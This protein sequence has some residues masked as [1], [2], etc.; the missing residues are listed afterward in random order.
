MQDIG[1][2]G[3]FLL[4]MVVMTE[5]LK[6]LAEALRWLTR[7]SRHVSRIY[8]YLHKAQQQWAAAGP[9]SSTRLIEFQLPNL[10]G[11]QMIQLSM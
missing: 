5:G 7:L 4:G 9:G 10:C 2:I 8:H 3:V 11:M 1:D 6:A